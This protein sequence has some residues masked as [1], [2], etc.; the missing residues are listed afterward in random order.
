MWEMRNKG[1]HF[2]SNDITLNKRDVCLHLLKKLTSSYTGFT[3]SLSAKFLFTKKKPQGFTLI[4]VIVAIAILSII[5]A[6][7]SPL[8]SSY[9]QKSKITEALATLGT[10]STKM[11]KNYLDFR[12]Y[13]D[14]NDC[15]VSHPNT[16]NFSYSC[17]SSGQS[18]TWTATSS[19]GN[20]KYSVNNNF[21][22]MTLTFD[23]Q[24]MSSINCWMISDTGTCF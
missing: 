10:L 14:N 23:G 22:K 5:M 20:Y 7:A 21:D 12:K 1:N 4:E 2:I 11:E 9:V 18:Y 13:T 24:A 17:I 15:A 6:V 3:I 8:Y 19:D 16:D